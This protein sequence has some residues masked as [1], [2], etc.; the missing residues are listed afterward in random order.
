M[1]GND[2]TGALTIRDPQNDGDTY[3]VVVAWR[4]PAARPVA[5]LAAADP[6]PYFDETRACQD[7][8][9]ADFIRRNQDGDAYLEFAGTLLR[10]D[11]GTNRERIRG[12]GWARNRLESRPVTYECV[13]NGRTNRVVTASYEMRPRGRYSSLY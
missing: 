4:N 12:E 1:R 2:F 5:P 3:D 7:R 13:V 8:V 10:D 11:V 9:R 6:F